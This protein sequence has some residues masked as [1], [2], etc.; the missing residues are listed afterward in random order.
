MR[1]LTRHTLTLTTL[2]MTVATVLAYGD[3]LRL[4]FFF[5]DMTHYI[6]LHG[7]TLTSIFVD[8]A[9]R[10]Y[11]RPMQFFLWKLYETVFGV[12]SVIFYHALSLFVHAIDAVLVVLLVRRLTHSD[13]WWPAILAGLI[14]TLFPFSY[15][16]VT[17]PAS[18]THPMVALFVLLSVLAYDSFRATGRRRWIVGSL[19]F[20]LLA[21]GS[22]EGSLLLAGLI[23]LVEWPHPPAPSPESNRTILKR[24]SRL[25]P[26]MVFGVMAA[27]YYLWYQARP[28]DVSNGFGLRSLETIIQNAIYALQGLT[29]PLQPLGRVLMTAG[30]SDQA[31]VLIIALPTLLVLAVLFAQARRFKHFV[32][33]VGWFALCL[34]PPV[35]IL[36]HDYF[37]NAPRVLYLASIGAAGLWAGTI[38]LI[39]AS[40]TRVVVRH[41]LA[42]VVALIVIVPSMMF[43]RQRMDLH[44]LNAAPLKAALN[45]ASQTPADT[46]L[47]F[48]NLPAWI[49]TPE[50]WYPIGHEGA[51]F[52]PSYSTMADFV[53]TNLNRPS[54]AVA[55]EFNSL[56]TPQPYY[57]GV[58]GPA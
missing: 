44:N 30:L 32:F 11:Y 34:T 14:F 20:G 13:R 29:F 26:A 22:N 40:Q 55:V 43:I 4:P 36:S 12:D 21:F 33:G 24:G 53:S 5:D 54:Q 10:P 16:V 41:G 37:I 57:Y 6:W 39:A 31:A 19:I 15:Q 50:L 51:L 46:K 25:L 27:L 8:A 42:G 47:L 2:I 45:V 3:A 7:Q 18:F 35:L 58:Y 48:V 56:S 1:S 23:A 38:D 17:L 49:S 28:H 9:G 52:M